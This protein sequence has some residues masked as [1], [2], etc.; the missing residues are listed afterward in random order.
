MN[1]IGPLIQLQQQMR[2]FH[3]QTKSYAE[4]KAFGKAYTNLDE[5]T[6]SFV[7]TYMGIYGTAKPTITYNIV[8]KSYSI[9]NVADVIEN[10]IQYLNQMSQEI[11]E[12]TDLLNIRDSILGE[13]NHLKYKLTLR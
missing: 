1:V 11:P 8:L 13:L 3:W 12:N 4:H 6:D 7:E 9:E 10:F 2:I 5:L